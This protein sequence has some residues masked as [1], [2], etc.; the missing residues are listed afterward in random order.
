MVRY[1]FNGWAECCRTFAEQVQMPLG[2]TGCSSLY[3]EGARTGWRWWHSGLHHD[4]QAVWPDQI[5]R[6]NTSLLPVKHLYFKGFAQAFPSA[7]NIFHFTW[8]SSSRRSSLNPF[9][10]PSLS[11]YLSSFFFIVI[12]R[13]YNYSTNLF[14]MHVSIISIIYCLS[15]ICY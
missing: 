2:R 3:W 14:C 15:S 8:F 7:R 12:T 6:S 1:G 11:L 13:I 4:P 5:C 9:S 10:S